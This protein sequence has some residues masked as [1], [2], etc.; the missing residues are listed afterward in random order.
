MKWL[1]F[2]GALLINTFIVT[3]LMWT[4]S[5]DM[6]NY[7]LLLPV[8]CCLISVV[9][10]IISSTENR[11]NIAAA[12]LL[13]SIVSVPTVYIVSLIAYIVGGGPC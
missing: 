5:V 12:T 11:K 10:L 1:W 6:Q 8:L 3:P 2:F 9:I 7:P 4:L 13:G